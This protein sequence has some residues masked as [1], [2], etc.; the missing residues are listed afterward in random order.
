MFFYI[1]QLTRT[2]KTTDLLDDIRNLCAMAGKDGKKVTFIFTDSDI[3]D[4]YFL[5]YI[6]AMLAT[7]EIAGLFPKDER[8]MMCAELRYV[9]K[10]SLN[11]F[12]NFTSL[13]S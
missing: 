10:G 1:S 9:V 4:E 5:E 6:N 11:L 3:I 8:D 7:G 12:Y 13:S 2:Y